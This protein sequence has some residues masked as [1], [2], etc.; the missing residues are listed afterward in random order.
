MP[1]QRKVAI[2][3]PAR[4]ATF[5][6]GRVPSH[7]IPCHTVH[8]LCF[9][10]QN[11]EHAR[12]LVEYVAFVAYGGPK[13]R[14]LLVDRKGR[15]VEGYKKKSEI[16]EAFPYLTWKSGTAAFLLRNYVDMTNGQRLDALSALLVGGDSAR[17]RA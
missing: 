2:H 16:Q 17:S 5:D 11:K 6:F 15:I 10:D 7:A 13:P 3:A 9:I 4:G 12:L 14:W 1:D 8:Y